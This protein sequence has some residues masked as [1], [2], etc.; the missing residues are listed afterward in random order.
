MAMALLNIV[1]IAFLL[2]VSA[3]EWSTIF[4]TLLATQKS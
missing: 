4:L 2:T 3:G 1:V